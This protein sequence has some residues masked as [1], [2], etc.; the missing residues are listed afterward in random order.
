MHDQQSHAKSYD[1]AGRV[2]FHPSTDSCGKKDAIHVHCN[3][4][5]APRTFLLVLKQTPA[6][7]HGRGTHSKSSV[8]AA[9]SACAR[10]SADAIAA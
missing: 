4:L 2:N 8:P 3:L 5:N 6:R 10:N 9:S 7:R 1:A